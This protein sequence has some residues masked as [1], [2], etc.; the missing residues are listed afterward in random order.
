[1]G[2]CL[3][4]LCRGTVAALS[5]GLARD[6]PP[7]RGMI[8]FNVLTVF[9]RIFLPAPVIPPS[10]PAIA[11]IR[12]LNIYIGK[13]RPPPLDQ[14]SAIPHTYPWPLTVCRSLAR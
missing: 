9:S 8:Q 6:D 7:S 1:V 14:W 11:S 12:A 2:H 4:R 3:L 13:N 10:W 5:V